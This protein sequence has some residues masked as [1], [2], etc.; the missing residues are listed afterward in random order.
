MVD[1]S[2]GTES[3]AA[4]HHFLIRRL[5]SLAGLVPVGVFLTFHLFINSTIVVGP[6][7]FQFGVDQIHK[8]EPLGILKLVEVF[9]I[10]IPLAFHAILGVK[11]W[12][13]GQPNTMAYRD[14]SN[15]RYTL[16]RVTGIAAFFFI[17]FHLWQMHWLGAPFGGGFF[18]PHNA[19]ASAAET[20]QP[21]WVG[22]V[23]IA[24]TLC[25]VYHLANGIWTALITWGITVG[26]RSQRM[27]GYAC[28]AFGIMLGI[29]GVAAVRGF[30]TL[31]TEPVPTETHASTTAPEHE[32]GMTE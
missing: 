15:I 22:P 31:E 12:L 7:A 8:I 30:K 6:E 17:M 24:G 29:A 10:F 19:A 11:I 23:Y 27:S 14:G 3:F 1:E 32:N 20:M 25:A 9:G 28:T 21:L 13:S 5:H 16:Q 26:P 2:A 18:D 4:R